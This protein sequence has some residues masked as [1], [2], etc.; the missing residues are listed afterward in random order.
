MAS[1]YKHMGDV[2]II[3]ISAGVGILTLIFSRL[4]C[5]YVLQVNEEGEQTYF[6]GFGFSDRPLQSEQLVEQIVPRPGAV[7]ILKKD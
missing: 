4:R 5:R 1:I 7:L 3:A 6:S 2:L